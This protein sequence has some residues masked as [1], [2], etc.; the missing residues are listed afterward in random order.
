MRHFTKEQPC[1]ICRGYPTVKPGDGYKCEGYLSLDGTT[2]HCTRSEFAGELEPQHTN[3]EDEDLAW[4][5][6]LVGN[7]LAFHRQQISYGVWV[8]EDEDGGEEIILELMC[9]KCKITECCGFP[10]RSFLK[11]KRSITS[12]LVDFNARH[13]EKSKEK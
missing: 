9:V 10:N 6:H 11:N 1:P 13:K 2:A 5:D 12:I 7:H 8:D 3:S 4:V